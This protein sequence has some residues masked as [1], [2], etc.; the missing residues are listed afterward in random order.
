MLNRY[1]ALNLIDSVLYNNP[2]LYNKYNKL[3]NP[4]KI[5]SNF[6][7]LFIIKKKH[8]HYNCLQYQ[9]YNLHYLQH[10]FKINLT[11]KNINMAHA[12]PNQLSRYILFKTRRIRLKSFNIKYFNEIAY[13]VLVNVWLKNSKNICKFIRNKLDNVHFKFH[14]KYFL[15]FFQIFNKYVLP[16]FKLLHLKGITLK[17][18]GKLGRGGNSRKK[19]LFY[20]KGYYS[21]SNKLLCLHRNSWDSWTK[22][23]SI[24][25]TFQLFFSSYDDLFNNIFNYLYDNI[26][27]ITILNKINFLR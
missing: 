16:N 25:C 14:R 1:Q 8:I 22:T 3:T 15:F 18:R 24:G 5:W 7:F 10:I 17:F 9:N 4:S 12:L 27:I 23:G 26:I 11:E 13:M 19:T 6:F 2:Q 20:K 21:L